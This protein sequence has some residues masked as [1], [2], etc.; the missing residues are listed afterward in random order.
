MWITEV[1]AGKGFSKKRTRSA[2]PKDV[3]EGEDWGLEKPS[4]V[5]T[6]AIDWEPDW[7]EACGNKKQQAMSF[8]WR[9][10]YSERTRLWLEVVLRQM[11]LFSVL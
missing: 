5:G 7:E 9:C 3:E 11:R 6:V 4:A 1:R 2:M 10:K 8:Y